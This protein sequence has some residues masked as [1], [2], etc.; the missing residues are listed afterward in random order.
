M[1]ETKK[2]IASL[3]DFKNLSEPII[4][5]TDVDENGK[6]IELNVRIK[7]VSMSNLLSAG[8]VPNSL[9]QKATTLQDPNR[10]KKKEPEY[11]PEFINDSLGAMQKIAE[12]VL[13]EPSYEEVKEF[14]TD[15]HLG[16][17]VAYVSGGVQSLE[18]FR[19]EQ[20]ST[21]RNIGSG[22]IQ[23]AAK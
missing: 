3:D 21:R 2:K 16:Q 5:I 7:R 17:I 11:S 15:N 23:P 13:V 8:I 12:A 9:M 14:L 6:P 19:N 10:N 18:N 1:A 22:E 4:T 20:E